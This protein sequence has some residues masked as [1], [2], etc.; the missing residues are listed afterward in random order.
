[1][2]PVR[3]AEPAP[4]MFTVSRVAKG[5]TA[6]YATLREAV[7]SLATFKGPAIIYAPDGQRLLSRG[8]VDRGESN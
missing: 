4:T 3:K 1:M 2:W 8:M 6:Q 7:E 5:T